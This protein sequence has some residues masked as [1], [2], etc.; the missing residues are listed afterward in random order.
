MRY[1]YKDYTSMRYEYK[2][3]KIKSFIEMKILLVCVIATIAVVV[4]GNKTSILK[5]TEK[6]G[7]FRCSEYDSNEKDSK[8]KNS[9][10]KD[11]DVQDAK[12]QDSGDDNAKSNRYSDFPLLA[13]L[14]KSLVGNI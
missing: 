4:C 2:D 8:D 10:D 9:N 13:D 5:C 11:G 7:E 12:D 1:D 3:Y 14:V 6:D